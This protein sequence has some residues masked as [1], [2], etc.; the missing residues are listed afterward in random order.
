MLAGVGRLAR[1]GWPGGAP[2][3]ARASKDLR[4]RRRS[5]G[6]R[7]IEACACAQDADPPVRAVRA[8]E[9]RSV[10]ATLKRSLPGYGGGY[11]GR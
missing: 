9:R 6:A 7:W 10:A 11:V 1:C 3:E 8:R 5:C 4:F 2:R